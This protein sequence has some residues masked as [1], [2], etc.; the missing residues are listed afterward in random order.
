MRLLFISDIH[1]ISTNLEYIRELDNKNKFDKIV[2]LGDIYYGGPSF[3]ET[4]TQ[5]ILGVKEFI[6]F[7]K[8]KIIAVRGNCDS[9]V[10]MK[11]NNIV[12]SDLTL[13][14]VDGIDL[15]LTHGNKYSNIKNE[16][17]K[18]KSGVLLFGHK[19]VP[20]IEKEDNMIYICVG[21]ISLPRNN[22]NPSYA[23]YENKTII[24]Y[25]IFDNVIDKVNL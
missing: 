21:S 12:I 15:Y 1:G 16:R 8:D 18:D 7:Y 23:I 2:I 11:A 20:F 3:Y 10:D 22:S 13:I 17:F 5:D 6:N 4:N 14:N 25:D 9:D 19:H 24:L